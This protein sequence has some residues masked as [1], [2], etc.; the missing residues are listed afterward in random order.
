MDKTHIRT[1]QRAIQKINLNG[2]CRMS[3]F[4]AAFR[5]QSG[6]FAVPILSITREMGGMIT[7]R[8]IVNIM[9]TQLYINEH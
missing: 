8:T 9:E 3:I 4:A 7:G 2:I 6:G 1:A 5:P